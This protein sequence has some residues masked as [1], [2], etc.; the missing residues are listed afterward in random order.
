VVVPPSRR[1]DRAASAREPL[2]G[3][4]VAWLRERLPRTATLAVLVLAVL[5]LAYIWLRP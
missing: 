5:V 1:P 2:R 4:R 3:T